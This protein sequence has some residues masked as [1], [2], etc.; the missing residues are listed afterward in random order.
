MSIQETT[1]IKEIYDAINTGNTSNVLKHF[2]PEIER[3][4]P[5]GFPSAGIYRGLLELE[6]HLKQS[7]QTWAEGSCTPERIISKAEK[8]IAFVKV[9]VRLKDKIEWIDGYV[10]DVFTFKDG[11]VIEMRSFADEQQAFDWIENCGK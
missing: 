6:A 9:H 1:I 10:T 7:S 4:E 3:H 5:L 11:K 8:F 2:A